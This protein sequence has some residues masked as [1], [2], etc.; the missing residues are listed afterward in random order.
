MIPRCLLIISP[1][2]FI[3]SIT[4]S[5]SCEAISLPDFAVLSQIQGKV[6]V[7]S[8]NKM[9]EG[10]N[11][12]LL[13]HRHRVKTE[14]N[15]KVTVYI[16]D[17]SQIR[18]FTDSELIVGAKKSRN[19]RWMR[20]RL[21][22]LSGGFWGHFVGN[23]NPIEVSGGTLRLQLS[24]SSIRFSKKK[25]G[26]DISVLKGAVR[27]FNKISFVKLNEGQR[28]YQIQENDFM[29]QKVSIIPNQ[30]KLSLR[31]SEPVLQ[32]N[33]TIELNLNLQVIRYGSDRNVD[34]PGPVHLWADYYN[35]E[36][37]DLIRLNTD[38]NANTKIKISPPSSEDRTFEGTVTF[39]A[40]MDQKGFDDVR[41]GKFKVRFKNH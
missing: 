36:L 7:G 26:T 17:G 39:H 40:I 15:G 41:D 9:V 22:L 37:P 19:S 1:V 24:D 32:G 25:A 13:R 27:V 35:L 6:K 3:L 16:K 18:L 4:L 29:P 21:V 23:K 10:A 11:G 8:A 2:F 38:G 5:R 33:K 20:Y 30:L 28:L 34:R 31:P 12:I 14:R